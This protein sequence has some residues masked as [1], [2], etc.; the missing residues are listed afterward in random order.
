MTV[1]KN[2]CLGIVFVQCSV[3]ENG[4]QI[5]I[6]LDGSKLGRKFVPRHLFHRALFR[7]ESCESIVEI[8]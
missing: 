7:I 4:A 8:L 6:C 1:D 5:C 2:H 3:L